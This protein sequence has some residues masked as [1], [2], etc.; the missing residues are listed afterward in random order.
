MLIEIKLSRTVIMA[1]VLTTVFIFQDC[2]GEIEAQ[3]GRA[4][5]MT[6]ALK[7]P[8][9]ENSPKSVKNLSEGLTYTMD[10]SGDWDFTYT[11]SHE[12][13]P[14]L[15]D[16]F[17]VTMPVPGC[18]DDV[19]ECNR[20]LQVWPQARFNPVEPLVYPVPEGE[21]P[22]T[23]SLPY[24]L[25]TG[26]YRKIID[27]PAGLEGKQ[28]TLEVGRVVMEAWVYVNGREVYHHEGHSTPWEVA[29][30]SLLNPGQPNEIIIAV[31][32][33][34][35]IS[36][37]CMIRGFKGRSSGIFGPVRLKVA[38]TVRIKDFYVWPE[39]TKLH[40]QVEIE[41]NKLPANAELRWNVY[42]GK[43]NTIMG[44]GRQAVSD[45]RIEWTT[46]TL[47]MKW[48]SDHEPNLYRI[49]VS[50]WSDENCQDAHLRSFGLRRLTT[51]GFQL[52]LNGKPV[53]LRG[54]CNHSYYPETC[55]PPTE[56][57]WYLRH[58]RD[59]KQ[60]GFNWIRFH[61]SV[62]LEPYL[63]AADKLGML[64]Q[65]EAPTG[66][67][68][69][70]WLDI[71]RF[72][73]KHPSVV[74]YCGGNEDVLDEKRIEL[75]RRCSNDLREIVPD[76]LFN[77]QTALRGVEYGARDQF[78]EGYIEKEFAT[79]RKGFNP[80]RLKKLKE[81]SDV[82]GQYAWGKLSY[83]SLQGEHGRINEDLA[84]YERPC[85]SHE[86][87]IIG[88]YR[89]LDL[90]QRY[91]GSRIGTEMFTGTRQYLEQSGLRDR[92]ALYF[93][94][95]SAWQYLIM[96]DAIETTRK[97]QRY[98][99]YELLGITDNTWIYSGYECGLMNEFFELKPGN[100]VK[101]ILDLNGES[102]LLLEEH[103]EQTL[104]TG[105]DFSEN[106]M[107]SWFGPGTLREGIVRWYIQHE[108]GTILCRGEQSIAP[109]D[110]GYVKT[111][112]NISCKIPELDEPCK[113]RL[114]VS[115]SGP[116]CELENRWH[117]WIFPAPPVPDDPEVT[118]VSELN[119][120]N[121]KQLI[122]GSRMVL[123]GWEPFPVRDVDFR[124]GLAGRV[125]GNLAT[126]IARH[127]LIGHFPHDG[128]CD[129]QFYTMLDGS[130]TV[131]FDRMDEAFDPI[132]EV[133]SSYNIIRKQA[134]L[135]EWRI[136]NGRLL[137]CTLNLSEKD[138]AAAYLRGCI[139]DYAGSVEFEPRTS[140][141]PLK[142]A[143][144]LNLELPD[145]KE[146]EQKIN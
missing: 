82:F 74:I 104:K 36:E 28:I 55:T 102:V 60:L 61:T 33:T 114:E 144:Y 32:N 19:F 138:P 73:R 124:I 70:Q 67:G 71:I 42:D 40:W 123:L 106:L 12:Q 35:E 10:L 133:V 125:N 7:P 56:N 45:S 129:W 115:L 6:A 88:C 68:E 49:E 59:L 43:N 128:Y 94:N 135:F 4:D 39:D 146:V 18:W 37:G 126:V 23:G 1:M 90:E 91:A 54:D 24:L 81:F 140:V 62:P 112:M 31:D 85:L 142:L 5:I 66:F 93:R 86:I 65:V 30:G 52:L 139:L 26:W 92:A 53:Y 87:G 48:W 50:L 14:P 143:Q 145:I 64:V 21:R 76:G 20:A 75:L 121:L 51:D 58:I 3:K 116:Q 38:G 84:I 103:R 137:V 141:A 9:I 29:I 119:A 101:N 79:G 78:G 108:N 77:P 15:Y 122:Q 13:N 11:M 97:I 117:Y 72:C 118:V 111:V 96:K 17:H 89:N 132:L 27:L 69:R 44:Q 99:G 46:D 130:R 120:E 57:E 109:I 16:A 107:L 105:E 8:H 100:S 113:A 80:G 134:S 95:S 83:N 22:P 47:G 127:P 136:G 110:P 131:V 25:G 98:S 34:R 63:E 2:A 41:G